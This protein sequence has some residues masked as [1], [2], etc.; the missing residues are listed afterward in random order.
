MVTTRPLL[1]RST[2]LL[3]IA[4]LGL[5]TFVALLALATTE[6]LSPVSFAKLGK[7]LSILVQTL[8]TGPAS[9]LTDNDLYWYTVL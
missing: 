5:C 4:E 8:L 7:L 9:T 2:P 6:P 3:L 1:R